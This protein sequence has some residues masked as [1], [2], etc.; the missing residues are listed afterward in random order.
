M[1]I[2]DGQKSL[3]TGAG[4][5]IGAAIALAMAEAGAN[6]AVADINA[7]A[8]EAVAATCREFGVQA[9]AITADCGDLE[10]IDG[11]IEAAFSAMGGLDVIVNNAG[12]TRNAFILDLTEADW[13]RMFRVNAKGVF[14]CMQGAAKRMKEAGGGRIINIAS[15]ASRGYYGSSNVAYAGTKGAVLAMTYVAAHQLGKHNI[16]VNAICPG[17]TYTNIVANLMKDRAEERGVTVE[18]MKR[19]VEKSIP[20]RRG[21]DP[22]DIGAMAVFLASPGARNITGQGFNV[23]GGLINS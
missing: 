10:A 8:A 20:I 23:D 18:D 21:N 11:M 12:V 17:V 13:D 3:V 15:V 9:T 7:E 16:N 19:D 1:G 6:V 22:E 5:G 4:G 14:F 2:L